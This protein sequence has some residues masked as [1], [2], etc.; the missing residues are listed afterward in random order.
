MYFFTF[1]SF[2]WYENFDFGLPC[3][4]QAVDIQKN[5]RRKIWSL[6]IDFSPGTY[7]FMSNP[8]SAYFRSI[9]RRMKS[10]VPS[11]P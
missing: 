6:S 4:R 1:L 2:G 3:P 10:T 9:I 7:L 8:S 11:I 5:P